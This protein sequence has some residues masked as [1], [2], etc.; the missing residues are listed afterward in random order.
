MTDKKYYQH[1]CSAFFLECSGRI[2]SMSERLALLSHKYSLWV[3]SGSGHFMI[4]L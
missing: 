4:L 3:A 2:D 1:S